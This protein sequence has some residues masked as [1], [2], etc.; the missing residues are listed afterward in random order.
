MKFDLNNEIDLKRFKER[1]KYLVGKCSKVE[2]NQ[3]R[4]ARSIKHNAYL[5]VCISLFAIEFGYT[6]KESKTL[7]KRE[8]SFMIYEKNGKRFL[9]ETS[10]QDSKELSYFIEWI[11]NYSAQKGLY[12]PD[13][14][15]YKSNKFNIDR[16]IDS[17]KAYL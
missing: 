4:E 10:K 16:Q 1:C 2:L 9:K 13:A 6:L 11:R 15:E 8:C 7:L 17:N 12:I 3:T 14:E 5:H